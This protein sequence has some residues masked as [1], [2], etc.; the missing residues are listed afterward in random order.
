MS[1][2]ESMESEDDT[3]HVK[4]VKTQHDPDF[5][6]PCSSLKVINIEPIV[7]EIGLDENQQTLV[8]DKIDGIFEKIRVYHN[9]N[10]PN[11][12]FNKHH[13]LDRSNSFIY[14]HA[15]TAGCT[16]SEISILKLYMVKYRN[17]TGHRS[18]IGRRSKK[19]VVTL[20]RSAKPAEPTVIEEESPN[21]IEKYISIVSIN[22]KALQKDNLEVSDKVHKLEE[23]VSQLKRAL[24][25]FAK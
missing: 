7:E 11:D 20:V 16:P 22:V 14:T 24:A 15:R 10:N 5:V 9:V 8:N 4:R 23:Q 21:V 12:E 6:P 3:Y 2:S 25:I 19:P 13:H 1:D 18:K 17:D